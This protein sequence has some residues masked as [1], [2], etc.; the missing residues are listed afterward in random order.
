M[1][2]ATSLSRRQQTLGLLAW[3]LLTFAAAGIGGYASAQAGTF[4]LALV[5]PDW[6]PPPWLFGPVWTVLYAFMAVSAWLVWRRR[7]V[8][9]TRNALVLFVAQ[10]VA[11]ALWTWLFFVWHQGA[12]AFAEVLLLWGLIAATMGVFRRYSTLAAALLLPYLAWVSFASALTFSLW[13]A[14]PGVLG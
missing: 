6:A 8:G 5:R 10:L 11:N 9:S 12:L 1:M 7:G 14:N 3:L 4:Y 13:Q 2:H